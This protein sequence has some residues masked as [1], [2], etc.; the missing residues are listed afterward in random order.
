MR[1]LCGVDLAKTK[2]RLVFTEVYRFVE[3]A[4]AYLP[5]LLHFAIQLL[6][7]N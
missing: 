5:Q 7:S 3:R 6:L 1:R 2:V 4:V